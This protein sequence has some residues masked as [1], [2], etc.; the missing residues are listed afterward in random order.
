MT[1]LAP[2]RQHYFILD[3]NETL[4][5]IL[6][7]PVV[8][9]NNLQVAFTLKKMEIKASIEDLPQCEPTRHISRHR[10]LYRQLQGQKLAHI[11]SL[12]LGLLTPPLSYPDLFRP[13]RIGMTG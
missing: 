11:R 8:R 1:A 4:L 7:Y 12:L 5:K 3:S 10:M 2:E 6:K 9:Q 13:R